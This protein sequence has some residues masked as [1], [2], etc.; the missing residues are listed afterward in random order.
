MITRL[1]SVLNPISQNQRK[2]LEFALQQIE[3]E[4]II[5]MQAVKSQLRQSQA[6]LLEY[7][8]DIQI[9]HAN[10]S[11]IN[12]KLS[13]QAAE[14]ITLKKTCQSQETRLIQ[15]QNKID[16]HNQAMYQLSQQNNSQ[17]ADFERKHAQTNLIVQELENKLIKHKM[18]N[19]RQ[20]QSHQ[21][22]IKAINAQQYDKEQQFKLQ[23]QQLQGSL[24]AE[25]TTL[26]SQ[27]QTLRLE[28]SELTNALKQTLNEVQMLKIAND[29]LKIQLRN[30][31]INHHESEN[32]MKEEFQ[33]A[34]HQQF[35]KESKSK[36]AD[37]LKTFSQQ[38]Q[39]KYQKQ[40]DTIEKDN[41]Q[42]KTANE[43]LNEAV[44]EKQNQIQVLNENILQQDYQIRKLTQNVVEL[45][46]NC[47]KDEQTQKVNTLNQII[48]HQKAQIQQL[49]YKNGSTCITS[50][51]S[52]IYSSP[53]VE[54]NQTKSQLSQRIQ[55]PLQTN[56]KDQKIFLK[57]VQEMIKI[58]SKQQQLSQGV[59]VE[60]EQV[61]E[62]LIEKNIQ[63]ENQLND[64]K[65]NQI[66]QNKWQLK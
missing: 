56:R 4:T 47:K 33:N 29:E 55:A 13:V 53:K 66:R 30:Q 26:T 60:P 61:I 45:T 35:D 41:I 57:S 23:L 17:I 11:A 65:F 46:E 3:E 39:N 28:N 5:E 18:E 37:L 42:L 22:I 6:Q 49:S 8:N 44:S 15:L 1:N 64:L 9:L 14:N 25:H 43:N 2:S 59:E 51:N 20:V 10:I 50:C 63:L 62:E 31:M 58:K 16:L 40:L 21:Q 19:E 34:F 48:I 32:Q 12:S 36:N 24:S 54:V 7:Q 38:I 52:Q 27:V